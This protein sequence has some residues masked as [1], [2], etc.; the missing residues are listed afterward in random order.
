MRGKSR[1]MQQRIWKMPPSKDRK[2][3]RSKTYP[4]IARAISEQWCGKIVK[5]INTI[6]VTVKKIKDEFG[7]WIFSSE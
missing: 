4:G 5:D 6:P 1:D 3:L 2:K 7:N